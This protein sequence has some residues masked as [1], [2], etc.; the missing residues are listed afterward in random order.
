MG[1]ADNWNGAITLSGGNLELNGRTDITD[2]TQ[3]FNQTSGTL[4]IDN[5]GSLTL[6]TNDSLITGSSAIVLGEGTGNTKGTL[7]LKNSSDNTAQVTTAGTGT[8]ILTVGNGSTTTTLKLTG[9]SDI[10]KKEVI[11]VASNS[12]LE[13]NG[14]S[15]NGVNLNGGTG[16]DT[17]AG[18]VKVTGGILN[19]SENITKT[20]TLT[21]ISG[22]GTTNIVDTFGFTTADNITAGTL[23]IGDGLGSNDTTLNVTGGTITAGD[24]NAKVVINSDSVINITGGTVTLDGGADLSKVDWAGNINLNGGSLI[25]NN[26]VDITRD[27]GSG[28][29]KTGILTATT[30]NLT[31]DSSSVLLG[32]TDTIA[33][34]VVMT[35]NANLFI[36]DDGDETASVYIGTDDT[37]NG[38]VNLVN[39]GTL[40]L[41]GTTTATGTNNVKA[42][43]GTLNLINTGTEGHGSATGITFGSTSDKVLYAVTTTVNSDLTIN[44]GQI[45][46]DDTN[47]TLTSGKITLGGGQLDLK[48]VSTTNNQLVANTGTLNIQGSGKTTTL[49]NTIGDSIAKNVAT[50]I[51]AGSTLKINGNNANVIFDGTNDNWNGALELNAG[52]LTFNGRSDNLTGTTQTYIQDGGALTLLDSGLTLANAVNKI[53]GGSVALTGSTTSSAGSQLTFDNGLTTNTAVI[54][55]DAN[56]NNALTIG[57]TNNTTLTLNSGSDINKETAVTVTANGILNAKGDSIKGGGSKIITNDGIFNLT[58]DGVTAGTIAR[59]INNNAGDGTTGTVN[60]TG[61]TFSTAAGTI[62][63]ANVNVGDGSGA[64]GSNKS[65]FT[66]GANVTAN[67]KLT[68]E[69]DGKII[70][71]VKNIVAQ[72][73]DVKAGGSIIGDG[74]T[75]G[76]LTVK[77]GGTNAGIISQN[78]VTLTFGTMNNTGTLTS[79][80]TFTNSAT[81]T[82]NT[83]TLNVNSGSST[84]TI[85]QGNIKVAGNFDNDANM[86][87]KTLLNV[88]ATA[89]LD[90]DATITAAKLT[91]DGIITQ[92]LGTGNLNISGTGSYNSNSITQNNVN[93]KAGDFT[94]KLGANL[95]ATTKFTNDAGATFVNLGTVGTSGTAVPT[96]QNDGTFTNE[97]SG[98][99][100]ATI[101]DNNNI[102][103]NKNQIVATTVENDG[104]YTNSGVTSS[105]IATTINNNTGTFTNDG[106]VGSM[107]TP[108]TTINNFTTFTNNATGTVLATTIDNKAGGTFTNS[109]IVGTVANPVNT[110]LNNGTVFTN[111]GGASVVANTI[112]N[113]TLME[114]K[115][116]GNI[117]SVDFTNNLTL[118][119]NG[120]IY[121]TGTFT[122]ASTGTVSNGGTEGEGTLNVFNGTNNGLIT[123]GNMKIVSG[124][125]GFNNNNIITIETKLDNQG[126]FNNNKDIIVQNSTNNAELN[127]TG[128][129]NSTA[130]S[131][132]N[133]DTLTN[134]GGIMN[135]TKSKVTVY[136]Q[137]DDIKGVIDVLGT[138]ASTDKT[139]LIIT[140]TKPNFAGTMNVGN[141]TNPAFKSTL[142]L[143]SGNILEE[144]VL[145]VAS[146]N[147][148][149]VDD[150]GAAGTSSV[151]I[152]GINDKYLGDI[153][154]VS[155][156]VEMKNLSVTTGTTS[157]TSGGSDPYY[158]QTGGALKLTNSTLS[159]RD[160]SLISGG[161]MVINTSSV[162]NSLSKSFTVNN[163]TNAGLV[164]AINGGYENYTINS[165]LYAGD[166][167]VDNQGN[168]TVDLYA[169]SNNEKLFDSFGSE[170]TT[171]YAA[172]GTDGVLHISDW[173]IQGDLFGGGAPSERYILFPNMIN[174]TVADGHKIDFTAVDKEII[175]PIGN[176]RLISLGGGNYALSL[177]SFNPTAHRGQVTTIAQYQNQLMIDDMIFNHTMLDQ[178]FK[179]NDYLSSHPNYYASANDLYAPYQYSKKDGGL[180]VKMYGTFE[181]LNMNRGLDV[182]NNAYGAIVGADF[183]LKNLKRGWQFMPTAYIAYNGGHQYWDGLGAYQNGGQMGF[184]G[185]WYKKNFMIGAMA[186]GGVYGNIMSTPRGNDDTFNYFAGISVKTAYNW[187]FAKDWSLQPN[188]LVAYNYFGQQNWHTNFGQMSMMSGMLHGVNIAPGVNLIWE[189]ETFSIYATLQYMYNIN[190]SVGG[191]SGNVNLPRV[192]MDRGYIQY[193]L[194]INK[195]FTDR[196]SGYL[197]AVLRNVGRTGVSLQMGFQWLLGEKGEPIDKKATIVP[198]KEKTRI[199]LKGNE[200]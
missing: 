140:G 2:A 4:T 12:T 112:T 180:W 136:Y 81:V 68:V 181:R 35:L 18:N 6:N 25:L 91:N 19:I 187:R 3:R 186:Y 198:R 153:T 143:K 70:N 125:T 5:N 56:T 113:N 59:A 183:G 119:N 38:T 54:T 161:D 75:E 155:G 106:S 11:T 128:I 160:S 62:N 37:W 31:I 172:N 36:G 71:A 44:A 8:N 114:N 190:Q 192:H 105:L 107:T 199:Q 158:V 129:I 130:N 191:S 10:A 66:M 111:N 72:T 47:D 55:S 99:I 78:N 146:E 149:N 9:S 150:S 197:Q 79:N 164:N 87:A 148:L 69:Q 33:D 20:G 28:H 15:S 188:L 151:V 42:T 93:I 86:E 24:T 49:N 104:T 100:Y 110:I 73:I 21:Q 194:G 116:G 41:D 96:I 133:A 156:N 174:G 195:R 157:T 176:Y 32:D 89:T 147:V 77:N 94:N 64:A 118:T 144:A 102:I 184:L 120:T 90:N 189:K 84:G 123:Q 46:L 51:D 152:D 7:I 185:T 34:A 166:G 134:T 60:L 170:S 50:T 88:L 108:V 98:V 57:G 167:I 76:N 22:N 126:T 39:S 171:I 103:T 45:Q 95:M 168:F 165:G 85:T 137:A 83:G 131:T 179:G 53:T 17:W 115:L 138:D 97:T 52:A 182:G 124:N 178:G 16:T 135:L 61:T 29:N 193:G 154:L 196:F 26:I 101:L 23:N 14:T 30:G 92:T 177:T 48:G 63:Q 109:G 82:G 43:S 122:N 159:M 117:D 67:T 27:G 200:A 40:T 142:N 132:I 139:D 13:V 65:I 127:N 58:N 162:F 169:R 173:S 80:G 163:L 74:A 121:S 141:T 1:T 175:T 145:N